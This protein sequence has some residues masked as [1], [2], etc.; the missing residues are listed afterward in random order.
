MQFS[1][2]VTISAALLTYPANVL[3]QETTLSS[4]L[5]TTTATNTYTSTTSQGFDCSTQSIC[6]ITATG[7]C[8]TIT[9]QGINCPTLSTCIVPDCLRIVQVTLLCGCASIFTST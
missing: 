9:T 5:P 7:T 3:A 2:F 1:I 4:P 6:A 8:T